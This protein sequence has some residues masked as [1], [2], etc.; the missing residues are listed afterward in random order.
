MFKHGPSPPFFSWFL[1]LS[2][3]SS[4]HMFSFIIMH[5][6]AILKKN[7]WNTEGTRHD[8]SNTLLLG[9][10]PRVFY[11]MQIR[12]T[13][14]I[15]KSDEKLTQLT[16]LLH[17]FLHKRVCSSIESA[18]SV[19]RTVL[20]SVCLSVRPSV[21]PSHIQIHGKSRQALNHADVTINVWALWSSYI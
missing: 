1:Q 4:F 6:Y 12:L 5:I 9:L 18:L 3:K 14:K 17:V 10:L 11:S 7:S 8:L 15:W 20:Q 2:V 13:G 19:Q 21:R 16:Q